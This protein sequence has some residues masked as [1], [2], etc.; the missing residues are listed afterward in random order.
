MLESN[1]K[2][3]FYLDPRKFDDKEVFWENISYIS[4][5]IKRSKELSIRHNLNNKHGLIP[6]WAAIEVSS[7]GTLSKIITNVDKN[8]KGIRNLLSHY[9]VKTKSGKLVN[10]SFDMF[11]SWV[12]T[13]HYMRNKCCHSSRLCKSFLVVKPVLIGDD[14]KTS[15]DNLG[16]FHAIISMKYLLSWDEGWFSFIK[17]LNKIIIKYKYYINLD[18]YFFPK[19]WKKYLINNK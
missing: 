10:P 4:K 7:F 16:C 1:N 12:R 9:K 5:E 2:Q 8:N 3:Y 19:N 15:S 18:Y 6:I 14:N 13:C 11:K 17:E